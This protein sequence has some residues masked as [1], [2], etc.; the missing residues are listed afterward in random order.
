MGGLGPR[1]LFGYE[2]E[3]ASRGVLQLQDVDLETVAARSPGT[4][5][6]VPWDEPAGDGS[7]PLDS[8]KPLPHLTLPDT[9]AQ[10][11]PASQRSGLR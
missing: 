4:G 2:A 6:L 1:L 11:R 10:I 8:Q 7:V 9:T 5:L 3:R